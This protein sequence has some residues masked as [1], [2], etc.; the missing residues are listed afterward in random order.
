M[1]TNTV[2]AVAF[3]LLSSLLV[4]TDAYWRMPCGG[5]LVSGRLDPIVDPGKPSGHTH[6]VLGGNGFGPVMDYANTQASTCTSCSIEG[7]FSNYWIPM[8]YY[9]AANG[10]FTSVDASGGTVYYQ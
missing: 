7:D 4:P 3:G 6:M 10:S 5:T 8:L 2:S 9:Q 1:F